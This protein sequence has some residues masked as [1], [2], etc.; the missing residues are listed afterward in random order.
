MS[1]NMYINMYDIINYIHDNNPNHDQFINYIKQDDNLYKKFLTFQDNLNIFFIYL[2]NITSI[3]F[4]DNNPGWMLNIYPDPDNK[5]N[6]IIKYTT[7]NFIDYVYDNILD[8]SSALYKK[9][10]DNHHDLII[11][12]TIFFKY[13]HISVQDYLLHEL[14]NIHVRQDKT[15]G[16]MRVVNLVNY[17]M[18]ENQKNMIKLILYMSINNSADIYQDDILDKLKKID[19]TYHTNF[20]DYAIELHENNNIKSALD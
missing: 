10:K 11:I 13:L 5:Y 9:Y 1:S 2:Q 14:S 20:Y 19:Y 16:D 12:Y 6:I 17:F 4:L 8:M 15:Y 18:K 7:H 3:L